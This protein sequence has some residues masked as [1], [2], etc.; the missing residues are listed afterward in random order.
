MEFCHN[1][2]T[3]GRLDPQF[4]PQRPFAVAGHYEV[5]PCGVNRSEVRELPPRMQREG[6]RSDEV[7][8]MPNLPGNTQRLRAS[9]Y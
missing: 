3:A 5:K 2:R 9:G 6:M 1:L 7:L 8:A 4:R